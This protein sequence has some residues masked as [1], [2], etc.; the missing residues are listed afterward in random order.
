RRR[1][2]SRGT[3]QRPWIARARNAGPADPG[4]ASGPA[5]CGGPW[6]PPRW[7]GDRGPGPRRGLPSPTAVAQVGEAK[8]RR[9][10]SR[11]PPCGRAGSARQVG[12]VGVDL[13]VEVDVGAVHLGGGEG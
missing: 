13:D 10:G 12:E 8:G 5:R 7:R 11:G 9:T 2:G 4:R 6:I 3:V 1:T